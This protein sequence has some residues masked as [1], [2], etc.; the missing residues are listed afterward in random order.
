M[1]PQLVVGLLAVIG[2]SVGGYFV[3]QEDS[4]RKLG[5]RI[6]S[7]FE[8]GDY[9]A[10]LAAAGELKEK[11]QEDSALD[12]TISQAAR[13]LVAEVSLQKAKE[14]ALEERWSDARALLSETDAVTDPAFKYHE[15]AT[16]LLQ[17][18][19]ALAAKQAHETAVT[20]STLK[21]RADSEE[22]KRKN[23]EG[24]LQERDT[25]LTK[26]KAETAD[27]ERKLSDSRKEAQAQQAALLQEQARAKELMEK[28]ETET[29]GKF[30]AEFR[31]YRDM[32]QKGKEQLDLAS[33]EITAKRD[34]TALIYL[35]GG[36]IL[37]DEAKSKTAD[38]R[39]H[40]TPTA[41]QVHVDNLDRA[42]QQLLEAAKQLQ[43]AVVYIDEQAGS[44]FTGS[45]NQGKGALAA[46]VTSL[47]S[48]S[49]FLSA[50]R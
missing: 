44:S 34:V 3:A 29:R 35:S 14:A 43:N 5:A 20:I 46:G 19:D 10:A 9:L 18:A 12:D 21:S 38:L 50:N 27:A 49:D 11:G 39:A 47:G 33:A 7:R 4:A 28:I 48:V 23:L 6:Q 24:T 40:R 31:A 30:I 42:L 22:K 2:L 26:S 32:A 17:E 16:K 36:K 1:I 15:E 45:F 37:F 13:F 41:Y 8:S 25:T